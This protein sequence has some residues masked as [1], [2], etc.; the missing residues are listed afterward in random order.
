MW[1]GEHPPIATPDSLVGDYK[2]KGWSEAEAIAVLQQLDQ[3]AVNSDIGGGFVRSGI[4]SAQEP[5][6]LFLQETF[7]RFPELESNLS[8]NWRQALANAMTNSPDSDEWI[9]G[10][11]QQ[12]LDDKRFPPDMLNQFLSGYGFKILPPV[13][14]SNL[15]GDGRKAWIY[16][17]QT[18]NLWTKDGLVFAVADKE[19]GDFE[20]VPIFSDWRFCSG[21]S[22][23]WDVADHNRNGIPEVAIYDGTIVYGVVLIFEWREGHWV[24]LTQN[25]ITLGNYGEWGYGSTDENGIE[26][27]VV[28]HYPWRVEY[29][30]WDGKFYT[31]FE[32][33]YG[34][35][36]VYQL[37]GLYH[38]GDYSHEAD[39]IQKIL[40]S[41]PNVGEPNADKPGPSYPDYLRFQLGMTYALQSKVGE[42]QKV[43]KTIAE[44]PVNPQTTVLSRAARV[45]LNKYHENT[46]IYRACQAAQRIVI[47]AMN[48]YK[49]EN[50]YVTPEQVRAIL[51]YDEPYSFGDSYLCNSHS[52]LPYLVKTLTVG[53]L[54]S[55]PVPALQQAGVNILHWAQLDLD[56]DGDHDWV[57]VVKSAGVYWSLKQWELWAFLNTGQRIEVQHLDDLP[58]FYGRYDTGYFEFQVFSPTKIEA[59]ILIIK[60]GDNFQV[61]R[62]K[63]DDQV[64]SLERVL[65][66]GPVRKYEIRKNDNSLDI[67]LTFLPSKFNEHIWETYRWDGLTGKLVQIDRI[68]ELLFDEGRPAKALPILQ[69]IV[70]EERR[71][72]NL[73]QY[74]EPRSLYLLGL[75]YELMGNETEA[76]R[77]YWQIWHDY[78]QSS[79][80]I[81]AERKL[82]K[83]K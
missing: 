62:V 53:G 35:S 36:F 25:Q 71:Q 29:Y 52:T 73:D 40:A 10:Q 8:L 66:E 21:L 45:F 7:Y 16:W 12:G 38:S 46:D 49:D 50:G 56:Y 61:Y 26:T 68:T 58:D 75:A 24:E 51:G 43:F 9:L 39:L 13:L 48:P 28:K 77:T 57:I 31:L 78:P 74:K 11:L 6:K 64:D 80:A 83:E 55:N 76:V 14:A 59:P 17:L 5:V 82:E 81:I 23:I 22:R 19:P 72:A 1:P 18:R 69:Y 65:A 37:Y 70:S 47:N 41:W 34:N 27:I 54:I 15:F 60:T 42:A 4:Q 44:S 33:N 63:L 67:E 79:Y 30:Q 20:I 2:L 3:Y 32:V